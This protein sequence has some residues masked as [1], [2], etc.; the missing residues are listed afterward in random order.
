MEP[1]LGVVAPSAEREED[2]ASMHLIVGPL[3]SATLL[4]SS[5]PR[6][7]ESGRWSSSHR[8]S[9]ELSATSVENFETRLPLGSTE[10]TALAGSHSRPSAGTVGASTTATENRSGGQPL[11]LGVPTHGHEGEEPG[12]GLSRRRVFVPGPVEV[13]RKMV[14]MAA[15]EAWSTLHCEA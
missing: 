3:T 7:K 2:R 10:A 13:V 14:G 12:D 9:T 8:L 11:R 15:G 4:C 5:R 6:Q 1:I